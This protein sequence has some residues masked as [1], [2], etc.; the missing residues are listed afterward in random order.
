MRYY[1]RMAAKS[2]PLAVGSTGIDHSG[3]NYSN[4]EY[5]VVSINGIDRPTY[6]PGGKPTTGDRVVVKYK[7]DGSVREFGLQTKQE[8]FDSELAS[9]KSKVKKMPGYLSVDKIDWT[10]EMAYFLGYLAG[11]GKVH[12]YLETK[13]SNVDAVINQYHA[14]TGVIL[15]PETRGL[16]NVVPDASR[17]GSKCEI[18]FKPTDFIPDSIALQQR[19]PGIISRYQLFWALVEHGFTAEAPQDA[20]RIRNFVPANVQADFDRGVAGQP[21]AVPA[22]AAQ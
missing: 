2:T 19:E 15:T 5:V 14:L 17:R 3:P 12:F 1:L 10:P 13:E 18:K 20:T 9:Q 22:V 4:R 8:Q 16:F 11:P 7:D 21:L 6:Y